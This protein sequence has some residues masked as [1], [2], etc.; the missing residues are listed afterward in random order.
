M[1]KNIV[2]NVNKVYVKNGLQNMF[3][4]MAE[5]SITY[6]QVN[7]STKDHAFL[8]EAINSAYAHINTP[9]NNNK[10]CI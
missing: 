4:S 3:Y 2:K 10:F 7:L 8:S 5:S 6:P 9:N 1:W